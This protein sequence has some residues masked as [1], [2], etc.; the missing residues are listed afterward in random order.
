MHLLTLRVK[1]ASR[2][3]YALRDG[4][5]IG[6]LID[7]AG[8]FSS[9][10]FPEATRFTSKATKEQQQASARKLIERF[11][12]EQA[13]RRAVKVRFLVPL[14]SGGQRMTTITDSLLRSFQGRLVIDVPRIL[15][16]DARALMCSC[17]M[18][19]NYSCQNWS[20]P[21]PWPVRCMSPAVSGLNPDQSSQT[22]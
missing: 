4:E 7:R 15:A 16:G 17:R 13:S 19:M 3:A 11:Q 12:R 10:A 9:E 8:G 14:Q 18:A 2:V 5:T 6:S 22:I 1:F 20:S 21:S